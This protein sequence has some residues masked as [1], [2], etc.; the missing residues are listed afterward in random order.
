MVKDDLP[1]EKRRNECATCM[2]HGKILTRDGADEC[3]DCIE[4]CNY[5]DKYKAIRKPTCGCDF[6]ADMW[7]K[8]V[9]AKGGS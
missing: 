7:A 9:E 5:A 2:D 3:P 8:A 4:K 1:K 6:C